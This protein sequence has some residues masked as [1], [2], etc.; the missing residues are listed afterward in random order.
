MLCAVIPVKTVIQTVNA[1]EI[2]NL[3]KRTKRTG[4]RIG[5]IYR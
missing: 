3:G 4:R 1:W 2:F 5:I